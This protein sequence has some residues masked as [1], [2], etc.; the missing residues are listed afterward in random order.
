MHSSRALGEMSPSPQPPGWGSG[1]WS[2]DSAKPQAPPFLLCMV[3][4]G[5]DTGQLAGVSGED[6]NGLEPMPRVPQHLGLLEHLLHV[7][8]VPL[9][10][11]ECVECTHSG[12]LACPGSPFP[13]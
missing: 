3:G 10:A 4:K 2:E 6:D 13:L 9:T 7:L 11:A 1:S 12:M 8:T 5:T